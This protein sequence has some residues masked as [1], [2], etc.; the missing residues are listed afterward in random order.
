M[1]L[2]QLTKTVMSITRNPS[3]FLKGITANSLDQ[4]QNAFLTIH[5][6][7]V[8][9]F[10]Q[11][12]IS[13]DE[14]WIVV[15]NSFIEPLSQH[16][17]RYARLSGVK[18]EKRN[19]LVFYD[20]ESSAALEEADVAISQPAGRLILTS[21]TLKTN[22][23]DNE[24]TVFRVQNNLPWL[25]IDYKDEFLLNVSDDRFVSY[26][27]GCFLGQEP[28]AKVHNRSKPSWKLLVKEENSCSGDEK[29]KMTSRAIDPRSGNVIG[30]VFVRQ[31]VQG[32]V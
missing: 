15:E 14:I 20:L 26:T 25:G 7:I 23:S 9:T 21:R 16:I 24:F 22:V 8:A 17:D 3:A 11:V 13:D 6:R 4:P 29:T 2:Y 10:D 19:D 5:G 32:M 27:K 31:S 12:N 30:F 18:I 1:K 28:V